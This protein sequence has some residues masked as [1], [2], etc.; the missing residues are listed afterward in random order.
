MLNGS[1]QILIYSVCY[2]TLNESGVMKMPQH[3]RT[4]LVIYSIGVY[5]MGLCQI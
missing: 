4:S 5:S 2:I 3:S 1:V